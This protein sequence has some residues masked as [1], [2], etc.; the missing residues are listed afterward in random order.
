MQPRQMISIIIPVYKVEQYLDR[1]IESVIGQTYTNLEIILVDDGS[2]DNCPEM[3]DSWANKDSRIKVIHKENG[4]LSDARNVGLEN[5]SGNLIGFVDSDDWIAPEMYERLVDALL[6]NQSDI[7]ACTVKMVWE[8][9]NPGKL[10]TVQEN[11]T[12]GR[13]EAQLALLNETKLKQPVWYKLYKKSV[14]DRIPFEVGKQHEDAYWSYQA[15]GNAKCVSLIDYI[16]YYYLQ[17]QDS[18]MGNNTY[19]RKRL[20]ALEAVEQRYHYIAKE[21]PELE[22]IAKRSIVG[23]CIYHGQMVLK[24]LPKA[25]QKEAFDYLNGI[26][27]RY[28]LEHKDYS[29]E[30]ITHKVWF[31]IA[32]KSL[33]TV[34]RI[35]NCLGVGM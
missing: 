15:V 3:C 35:K 13:T 32:G 28:R 2:P 34:C 29:N 1:C 30:K 12:L 33:K 19:T 10:L 17:R 23:N 6:K 8:D 11:C 27:D 25:E 26:N 16:G 5:A 7:A 20:D 18:I 14:I 4:G 9:G 31:H 21:F 22:P 24:Y